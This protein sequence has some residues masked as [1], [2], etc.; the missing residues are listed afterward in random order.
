MIITAIWP[1]ETQVPG[2]NSHVHGKIDAADYSGNIE[3]GI[4]AAEKADEREELKL[5]GYL[6]V[7]GE[8]H[9]P[10]ESALHCLCLD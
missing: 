5:G 8:D 3:I 9:K 2:T 1:Q 7:L 10:C 6:A 4:L